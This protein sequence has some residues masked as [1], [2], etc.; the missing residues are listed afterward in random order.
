MSVLKVNSDEFD[1][2]VLNAKSNVLVDF[3]ADWCGPCRMLGPVIEE[4]SENNKGL[5]VVSVNVDDNSD[6]AQK[7][8]IMSIPCLILF[9]DGKESKR[10]I[11]L[12]S[13]EELEELVG[14]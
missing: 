14:E 11:G 13:K 9:K 6:L 1:K 4:L 5:K 2:E 7:Y 3:N 8:G 10:S 12:V